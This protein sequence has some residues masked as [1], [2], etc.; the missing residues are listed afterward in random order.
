VP[1]PRL[2]RG[3][4]DQRVDQAA[5]VGNFSDGMDGLDGVNPN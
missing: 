3:R 1:I 2:R 4:I 5:D